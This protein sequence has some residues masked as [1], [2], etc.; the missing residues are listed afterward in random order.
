M[1][2]YSF[3]RLKPNLSDAIFT[4]HNSYASLG[5]LDQIQLSTEGK[6]VQISNLDTGIA[7]NGNYNV[8]VCDCDGVDLLDITSKVAI[9]EAL[10]NKGIPQIKFVIENIGFDFYSKPIVLKFKHTVSTNVWFSNIINIS[11]EKIHLTSLFI[12]RDYS[13]FHGI[14]YNNFDDYQRIRLKC[15]FMGNDSESK[16]G[17]YTTF[18]GLKLTSRIIET[19]FEKYKIERLDNFTYL[20][21][22]KLLTHPVIYLNDYRI[23]NKQTLQSKD[24][25]G[26]TNVYPIDFKVAINYNEQF[27]KIIETPKDFDGNDFDSNDFLT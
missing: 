9:Y 13:D 14:A 17:E 11:D 27:S 8:F 18:E 25:E 12:Y 1:I 20:R 7:F 22:N 3:I 21:L 10:D 24:F 6:Y 26:G 16:S 2:D 15:V 4:A 5:Y 19:Q 23:T